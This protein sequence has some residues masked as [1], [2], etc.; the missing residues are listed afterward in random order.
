VSVTGAAPGAPP[1]HAPTG[2]SG[3]WRR[4]LAIH[5]PEYGWQMLAVVA[6]LLVVVPLI[7]IAGANP[8][9]GYRVLFDASFGSL[10]GFGRLLLSAVPL[11]LVG[12]G[13]ALPL[14]IG[15]FNIGGEGQ[16]VVGALAATAIGVKL[17]G[18]ANLPGSFILP[19]LGAAIA[20]GIVGAI[21]GGLK[22]WRGINEIITTIMLNFIGLELVQYWVSGPFRDQTLTFSSSPAIAPGYELD[23]FGGTAAIPTSIFVA[24]GVALIVGCAIH[25]S[26]V[27]WRLQLGGINP[28]LAVRQGVSVRFLQFAA[29]T[30]GGALAGIGGATEMLGNEYRV[31]E[32]F[33]PGWGFDAIAIAILARGN[34]FAVVPYAMF[35]AFL[36]NGS[37]VLETDLGVP[38]TIVTMVVGVPVIIVA[39][40]IGFRSYRRL[41]GA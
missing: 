11:I 9:S 22:A 26:K 12:L 30:A 38:G 28:R 2:G 32:D 1:A 8:A 31:G 21:A 13:V 7:A 20:G 33:S 15:L 39:A 23:T 6:S 18:P 16:L 5:G 14:R 37:G 17:P 3:T 24:V 35:F 27:G 36:R 19:L 10:P 41:R 40:V 29:L 25:Y 34:L 4:S